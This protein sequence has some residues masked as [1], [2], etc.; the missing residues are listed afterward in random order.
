MDDFRAPPRYEQAEIVPPRRS[1]NA[2]WW[3]FGGCGLFMVLCCT[4]II[5]GLAY[6]G[7]YGPETSVYTGNRVPSRFVRT[8]KSL[9]ALDEGEQIQFFYSDALTDIRD[10]FYFVSD[11]KVVIYAEATGDNPLTIVPF[12][13]IESA[14]LYRNESFFE[15]SQITLQL[16]DG[17]ILSFP[18]SSEYDR[19]E[20]FHQAILD[21]ID[22]PV[23][24]AN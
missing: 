18:V 7:T 10:G 4:G 6:L 16:K 3:I 11:R 5:G 8:M 9:G 14:E 20:Q 12:E 13:A 21:R 17:Q 1:S 15:D 19:D 23:G 22:A 2:I 24:E